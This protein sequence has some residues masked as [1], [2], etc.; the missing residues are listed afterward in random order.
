VI[1]G[2]GRLLTPGIVD[3]HHHTAFVLGDSITPGGGFVAR[4]SMEPEAK[5]HAPAEP[6]ALMRGGEIDPSGDHPER[7]RRLLERWRQASGL[8]PIE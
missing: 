2:R 6:A 8:K 4:L 5:A 3:L 7:F 1:E